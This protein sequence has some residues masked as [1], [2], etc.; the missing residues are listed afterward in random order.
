MLADSLAPISTRPTQLFPETREPLSARCALNFK[1][2]RTL[3]EEPDFAL[4]YLLLSVVG[5]G[6]FLNLLRFLEL[7]AP[8]PLTAQIA[9]LVAQDEARHVAFGVWKGLGSAALKPPN[10]RRNIHAISCE[11]RL[12]VEFERIL[13]VIDISGI[14]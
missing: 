8:D 2:L 6:T 4:A 5:E 13:G 12:L 9:G 7:Y 10:C 11:P 3:L 1:S 14:I